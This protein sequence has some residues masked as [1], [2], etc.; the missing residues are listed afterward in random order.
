MLMYRS[1]IMCLGHII[2]CPGDLA[3][4]SSVA[5]CVESMRSKPGVCYDFYL[6][7]DTVDCRSLHL[8]NASLGLVK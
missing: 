3:E 5:D 2:Y 6:K 7:G 8:L 1:R 4:Y